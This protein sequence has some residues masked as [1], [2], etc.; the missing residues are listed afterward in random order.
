MWS[1]WKWSV[2]LVLHTIIK[3][4]TANVPYSFTSLLARGLQDGGSKLI[5]VVSSHLNRLEIFQESS[6]STCV[7]KVTA[8]QRTSV[9]AISLPKQ[10]RKF[11]NLQS[12]FIY[13][14]PHFRTEKWEECTQELSVP[15]HDESCS[16]LSHRKA[17]QRTTIKISRQTDQRL[18]SRK[19]SESKGDRQMDRQNEWEREKRENEKERGTRGEDKRGKV[20][21]KGEAA[22]RRNGRRE[23][24]KGRGE[25]ERERGR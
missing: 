10:Q 22:K 7:F 24:R 16:I 11:D 6:L 8:Y 25:K 18:E 1:S 19:E 2:S 15:Q 17:D 3:V 20:E 21:S 9:T 13:A 5:M 14:W 4:L 23:G 12:K